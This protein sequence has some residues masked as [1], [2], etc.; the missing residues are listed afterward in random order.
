MGRP[1]EEAE[2]RESADTPLSVVPL[3]HGHLL[4]EH[5]LFHEMPA[6]RPDPRDGSELLWPWRLADGLL[7]ASL[8]L[9]PH[10]QP[11]EIW[12]GGRSVSVIILVQGTCS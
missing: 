12:G 7:P 5:N 11:E 2:A 1:D 8:C 3:V 9:G 6:L 4:D 10:R